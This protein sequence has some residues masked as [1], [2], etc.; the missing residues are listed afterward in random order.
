[1]V[2]GLTHVSPSDIKNGNLCNVE[3]SSSKITQN[4]SRS[5]AAG[6]ACLLYLI[7]QAAVDTL[8]TLGRPMGDGLGGDGTFS[9]SVVTAADQTVNPGATIRITD[10]DGNCFLEG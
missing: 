4:C 2:R 6:A 10:W 9:A 7:S 8:A 1:V 3:T 5:L